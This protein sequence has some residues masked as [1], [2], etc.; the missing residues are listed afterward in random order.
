MGHFKDSKDKT[1]IIATKGGKRDFFSR[2]TFDSRDF[3]FSQP[4]A[5]DLH[6]RFNAHAH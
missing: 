4:H 3:F 1:R 5:R 6:D 2:V